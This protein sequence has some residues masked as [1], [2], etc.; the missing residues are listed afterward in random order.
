MVIIGIQDA[1]HVVIQ[2]ATT[3]SRQRLP[4]KQI[5]LLDWVAEIKED[6]TVEEVHQAVKKYSDMYMETED[7]L[8]CQRVEEYKNMSDFER[9]KYQL[10]KE[11]ENDLLKQKGI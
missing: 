5:K 2:D 3:R 8:R 7:Y 4:I 9:F 1:T 11:I 6:M 10:K